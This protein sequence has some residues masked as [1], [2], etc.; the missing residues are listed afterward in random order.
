MSSL[1]FVHKRVHSFSEEVAHRL[2]EKINEWLKSID[3][4]MANGTITIDSVKFALSGKH[5]L[6]CAQIVYSVFS[7]NDPQSAAGVVS[8]THARSVFAGIVAHKL[9]EAVN[10]GLTG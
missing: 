10:D 6:F 2:E 5:D 3:H 4:R 7:A 8:W 9:D 1:K